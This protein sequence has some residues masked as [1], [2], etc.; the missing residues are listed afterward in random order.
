MEHGNNN[1]IPLLQGIIEMLP[2]NNGFQAFILTI[3]YILYG[4]FSHLNNSIERI[5]FFFIT[6]ILFTLLVITNNKG[7]I[8]V[9]SISII[10]AGLCFLSYN[11]GI[12][13]TVPGQP[14]PR[15]PPGPI[16]PTGP[17]G[18]TGPARTYGVRMVIG[19]FVH[20]YPS[21]PDGTQA[22]LT[23]ITEH[24]SIGRV[25]MY[26]VPTFSGFVTGIS[27]HYDALLVNYCARVDVVIGNPP[28]RKC[29]GQNVITQ[30][31]FYIVDG[32]SCSFEAGDS[33]TVNQF[34]S[35]GEI[36]NWDTIWL[37]VEENIYNE[38]TSENCS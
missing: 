27:G 29:V 32:L 38:C 14:G 20:W 35:S 11:K 33:I 26:W 1:H 15:G 19:P 36:S 23:I 34:Y 31:W 18:H 17:P 2:Q 7:R 28:K 12:Y 24:Q 25:V 8:F 6:L 30:N 10:M 9:G 5:I 16:G 3:L 4:F 21:N 13:I 37:Y 22:T